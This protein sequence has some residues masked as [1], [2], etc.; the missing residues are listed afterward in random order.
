M[1]VASR[2][3]SSLMIVDTHSHLN[4]K[5]YDQD[6]E[7]VLKH[8]KEAGIVCIA[9]GTK[10]QTSQNAVALAEK[11]E[12]V[13]ASIALHPIHIKTDF[14]KA[15]VDEDEGGFVPA[16]EDFLEEEYKKL[17]ASKKVVA[18]GEFGLDYYYK[19][20]TTGRLEQFKA[21]QKEV[22]L[23]QMAFA[24]KHDLPLI[25][26]CR[27]AHGDMI[28]LLK[29]NPGHRGV[30]HCFTG[31]VEEMK[32]YIALGFHIGINGIIFK[33]NLDEVIKECPIENI[34]TE[35]D[36]PYLTPTGAPSEKNEPAFITYTIQ[37]IA[38]LKGLTYEEVCQKTSENAQKLFNI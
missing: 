30:I 15:R 38:G 6:R 5:A 37:K 16:S 10:L 7:E 2:H 3:T 26:H 34:L 8:A 31:S 21:R 27:M 32:E 11:E 36:C 4:F 17:A 9:V 12:G 28:Q 33:L 23:Q 1:Y 18:V 19:P 25:I 22:C 14:I 35:T 24:K 20:K 29:E 13:Y